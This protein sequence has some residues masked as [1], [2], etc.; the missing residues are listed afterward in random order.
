MTRVAAAGTQRNPNSRWHGECRPDPCRKLCRNPSR[1]LHHHENQV[2]DKVCDEDALEFRGDGPDRHPPV[3][4]SRRC[5]SVQSTILQVD[6]I[7]TQIMSPLVQ[8]GDAN[9]LPVSRLVA[10][11][12]VPDVLQE[13]DHLRR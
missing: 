1:K 8:Q 11:R 3:A 13:Q 4:P 10:F 7:Q 12:E 2:Y 6:L 9:L 5:V